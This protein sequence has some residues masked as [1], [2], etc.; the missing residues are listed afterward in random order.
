M[1]PPVLPPVDLGPPR[2][3]AYAVVYFDDRGNVVA[4]GIFSEET[5]TVMAYSGV[6]ERT[7]C[8]ERMESSISYSRAARALKR[9]MGWKTSHWRKPRAR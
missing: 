9:H 3:I 2:Y 6:R 7:E 1:H 8:I 4:R 5:P